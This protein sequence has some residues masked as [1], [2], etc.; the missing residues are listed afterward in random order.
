[1][2]IL[3]KLPCR[4]ENTA[5][6]IGKFDGLHSGHRLL[7]DSIRSYENMRKVLFTFSFPGTACLYSTE[8]K[9]DLAE[10]LGMDVYID[11]PFDESFARMTPQA[12]VEE[13]L[14]K[15]CGAGAVAV[16]EDFRFGH[17]RSGD[18]EFLRKCSD[19]YG[20]D[21]HVFEKKEMFGEPVSS[22]RIRKA[23]KEGRIGLVNDLLGQPFFVYGEVCHGN[24][25]GQRLLQMP[26]ANQDPPPDKLLPPFGVYV[27]R[28]WVA[29]TSYTGVTNIGV[30]PTVSGEA[31]PGVE[32]HILDF[33]GDIY[34]EKIRVEL[35][36]F[37]RGER[38][39]SELLELK[40]QMQKDRERVK[41]YFQK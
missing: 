27:S 21:L 36:D 10:R 9:R 26:T 1:M 2:L 16:G 19:R 4:L 31:R 39:F 30:K 11:C 17:Q 13:I 41:K 22:T 7:L 34:G 24:Q 25:V 29:G 23:L 35:Y 20:F 37:L 6:C 28:V 3:D 38:K 18:V 8:E 33:D 12:F 14:V 5:V 40:Q 15:E 32:T